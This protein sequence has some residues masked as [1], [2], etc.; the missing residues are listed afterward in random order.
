[1]II[2]FVSIIIYNIENPIASKTILPHRHCR[3]LKRQTQCYFYFSG[4]INLLNFD[5]DWR[6]SHE[7]DAQAKVIV[8]LGR[9]VEAAGDVDVLWI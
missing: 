4:F 8:I 1:M 6:S 3:P 7:L 2:I 9:A 5:N